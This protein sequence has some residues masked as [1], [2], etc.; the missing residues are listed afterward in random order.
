MESQ[1][2]KRLEYLLAQINHSSM[3]VQ[4]KFLSI[5]KKAKIRI[6]VSKHLE[7]LS[8]TSQPL[9]KALLRS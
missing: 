3:H 8:I 2:V 1:R 7:N 4:Q 6:S 9:L 5:N